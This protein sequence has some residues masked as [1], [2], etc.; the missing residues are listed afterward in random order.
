V[1]IIIRDWLNFK[2]R[3][4]LIKDLNT[5]S[6]KKTDNPEGLLYQEKTFILI[7][8]VL[9]LYGIVSSIFLE[10]FYI[11]YD[12]WDHV[13]QIT[14]FKDNLLAPIDPY[15]RGGNTSHILT[16]YHQLLGASARITGL[17]PLTVLSIAGLFNLAFFVYSVR[18]AACYLFGDVKYSLIVLIVLLAFWIYPP[19]SSGVNDFSLIPLTLGYPYRAVFPI[20][21]IV[22]AKI[23]NTIDFKTYIFYTL[24]TAYVFATHPLSGTS[25][26]LLIGTKSLMSN[27]WNAKKFLMILLPFISLILTFFWPYYPILKFVFSLQNLS[28]FNLPEAYQFYYETIYTIAL[29]FIPSMLMIVEK[30]KTRTFD[31]RLL[32]LALLTPIVT[33]NYFFLYNEPIARFIFLLN[34]L[35]HLLTIE[36]F[37]KKWLPKSKSHQLAFFSLAGILLILQMEFSLRTISIFPDM[38]KD[39]SIGYHSNFRLYHEFQELDNWVKD[40]GI[41][42]APLDV[43]VMITRVTHQNAVVYYYPNPAI[44]G[45]KEKSADV[46]KYFSTSSVKEKNSILKKYQVKYLVSKENYSLLQKQGLKLKLLGSI[47]NFPVYKILDINEQ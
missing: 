7:A 41:I 5:I 37:I 40:G 26:M 1:Y 42:L 36:W 27:E 31:F 6:S 24:L 45:T 17:T 18:V 15:L 38:L 44:Y 3:N 23:N 33:I 30:I 35:L 39:K 20:I 22:L 34:F 46:I 43:S 29:I 14:A 28:V 13:A 25:L 10:C 9:L 32:L 16:P 21:I 19:S 11:G 12:I 8:T 4:F 2:F 47:D